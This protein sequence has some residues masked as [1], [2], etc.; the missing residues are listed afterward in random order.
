MV[1]IDEEV[2]VG[3]DTEVAVGVGAAVEVPENGGVPQETRRM[4]L[5]SAKTIHRW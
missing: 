5:R 2:A 3:C 1:L 4:A